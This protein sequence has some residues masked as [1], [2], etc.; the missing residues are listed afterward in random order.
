MTIQTVYIILLVLCVA[1]AVT[2]GLFIYLTRKV[3][4]MCDAVDYLL[5]KSD[6]Q[7][8][9]IAGLIVQMTGGGRSGNAKQGYTERGGSGADAGE[10][11]KQ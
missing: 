2:L 3:N 11:E 9:E 4:A 6:Y 5:R 7:E 10:D 1:L 8:G